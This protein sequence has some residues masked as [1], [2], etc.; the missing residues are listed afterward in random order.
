MT[1][2]LDISQV[3]RYNDI[4][5]IRE[6]IVIDA[7]DRKG[8]CKKYEKQLDILLIDPDEEDE[9]RALICFN[10]MNAMARPWEKPVKQKKSKYSAEDLL[11]M[12]PQMFPEE[13][14]KEE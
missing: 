9:K 7:V 5:I 10:A 2:A 12:Y 11:G 1:G 4:S 13:V 6:E 8:L 14:K 3:S